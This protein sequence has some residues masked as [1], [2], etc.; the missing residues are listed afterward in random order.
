M[1]FK[2][3]AHGRLI[4]GPEVLGD[5]PGLAIA[6]ELGLLGLVFAANQATVTR[7]TFTQFEKSAWSTSKLVLSIS[8]KSSWFLA[9][10]P[11]NSTLVTPMW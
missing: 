2:G 11:S 8:S 1:P 6:I 10:T 3:Q 5:L 4:G 9:N 7:L